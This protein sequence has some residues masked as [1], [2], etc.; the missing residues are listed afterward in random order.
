VTFAWERVKA[1]PGTILATVIVGM[2][3]VWVVGIV[4]SFIGSVVGGIGAATTHRSSSGFP[5]ELMP[6]SIGM[7]SVSWAINL[8][9]SSFIVAG[10]MSFALKVAK[11]VPYTFADLFGGAPIF[12]SVLV[13]N[14]ISGLAISIG[15][16]FLIVPGV[17][18]MIGLSMTLPLI[19]DRGLGPIDALTESWRLTDGNRGNIFIFGLIAFGLAVAGA[20]A[21]GIGIFLVIPLLYIAHMYIYLK[22]TNQPVAVITQARPQS[23]AY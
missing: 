2:V 14:L 17:I 7:L 9:V 6:L 19:V 18:L 11:G 22:L 23:V 5:F 8:V 1:D 15:L 12:V 21:C 3:L 10:I 13:A 20:C 16:V 4:M